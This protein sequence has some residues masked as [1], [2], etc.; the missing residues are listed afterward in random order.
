MRSFK[1]VGISGEEALQ[2]RTAITPRPIRIGIITPLK[3]GN[4]DEGLLA[5]SYDV[6][7]QMKNNLRDLLMT[8]WG[9]RVGRYNY[10]ANLEPLVTEY[11]NGPEQ[12]DSEAMQRIMTAVQ[13]WMPYIELEN[14][15]SAPQYSVSRG[16]GN[17]IINVDYSIPKAQIPLTRL[18]IS[19]ALS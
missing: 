13:T 18:Q 1:S 2:Q 15:E 17:V 5:M 10:G 14:F 8:N 3:E 6:G 19:F 4:N 11:E 12:F 16:L 9:E 7:F